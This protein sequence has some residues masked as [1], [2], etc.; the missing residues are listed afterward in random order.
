M[1]FKKMK[2]HFLLKR[3]KLKT[4]KNRPIKRCLR[5]RSNL[6]NATIIPN[7]LK[8]ILGD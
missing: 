1:Y 7:G 5:V 8:L 3:G 2:S 4:L 6:M